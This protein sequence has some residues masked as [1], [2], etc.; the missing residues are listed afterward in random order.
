MARSAGAVVEMGG[1]AGRMF[2]EQPERLC[3]AWR[4]ERYAQAGRRSVPDSLLDGVVEDFI[5]QIGA[6]LRHETTL[7]AWSRT[8]GVLRLSVARGPDSILEELATLR[9][10]LLD[11]LGVLGARPSERELLELSVDEA[12]VSCLS[13][14]Q[15][16]QDPSAPE[17]RVPFGG[18]VV[19]LIEPAPRPHA[20]GHPSQGAQMH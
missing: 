19:E 6:C 9:R 20:T 8:R 17:P 15:R 3:A 18:L 1:A 5:R 16:L 4:R 12:A 14:L 7:P 11:A 10:C 13:T 2:G